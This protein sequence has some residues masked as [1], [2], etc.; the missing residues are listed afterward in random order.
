MYCKNC[1]KKI[2]DDA[3]FCLDCGDSVSGVS[4]PMKSVKSPRRLLRATIA[5]VVEMIIFSLAAYWV[6]N[7]NEPKKEQILAI[8]GFLILIAAG[9]YLIVL[10]INFRALIPV[11]KNLP[12]NLKRAAL[13][14][15][16]RP[17]ISLSSVV[18]L[19]VLIVSANY[20]LNRFH[21]NKTIERA[22]E[23]KAIEALPFIQ[24]NLNEAA[25][26]KIMGDSIV[27]GNPVFGASMIRVEAIAQMAADRLTALSSSTPT[28]LVDY[29][30]SAI[31]WADAIAAAARKDDEK[32]EAWGNLVNQP[33][34]F[35][36]KISNDSAQKL[37]QDSAQKI[38]EL[39][40]F[41]DT[42]IEKKDRDAMRYIAAK[43]LVQEHWLNGIIH[44]EKTKLFSLRLA[45]AVLAIDVERPQIE[46]PDIRGPQIEG[47]DVG[48]PL[49]PLPFEWGKTIR[50]VCFT[51]APN[52][53][54]FYC[55]EGAVQA[56]DDLR[57]AA[58]DFAG[59]SE[60]AKDQW[61]S[62]W[63]KS[64]D[65]LPPVVNKPAGPS[66]RSATVQK[67]YNDCKAKGGSVNSDSGATKERL[68]TTEFGY[69]CEYK[70]SDKGCWDYLTYS[71]GVYAGG[72][73]GCPEQNLLPPLPQPIK[74]GTK[75]DGTYPYACSMRCSG[76]IPGLPGSIPVTGT[77]SVSGNMLTD[78]ETTGN[79][80]VPISYYDTATEVLNFNRSGTDKNGD[81]WTGSAVGTVYYQFH[82]VGDVSSFYATAMMNIRINKFGEL[83]TATC[84]CSTTAVRK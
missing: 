65:K 84:G 26:A 83:Y 34:D 6:S 74:A 25:A 32:H 69:T 48:G 56:V 41:G 52:V 7:S 54:T 62:A 55:A 28:L 42:A 20:G 72:A 45:P 29:R 24:E 44:S 58:N 4:S 17:K 33:G 66:G 5:F 21:E 61:T 27:A 76:N 77:V 35:Q 11:I 60:E 2:A 37:F 38:I 59:G 47:P 49:H 22:N 79:I 14:V 63:D 8:I 68:S 16:H 1:G 71:G 12:S 81:D 75:W 18:V 43:L 36:L 39:K 13:W 23:N 78:Q 80:T 9:T 10:I 57:D 31:V 46:R 3:K 19:I 30:N 64:K 15:I 51:N 82:Q 67:F 53:A 70:Q 73:S 50:D 40:E